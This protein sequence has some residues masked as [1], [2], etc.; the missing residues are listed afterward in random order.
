MLAVAAVAHQ[1]V[2]AVLRGVLAAAAMEPT[3]AVTLVVMLPSM[4]VEAVALVRQEAIVL[5]LSLMAVV[6]IRVL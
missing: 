3:A 5:P 2:A 1:V 6:A 4:A